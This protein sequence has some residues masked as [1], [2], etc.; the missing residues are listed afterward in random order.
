MKSVNRTILKRIIIYGFLILFF[1]AN[2]MAY[3]HAY[4]FTHFEDTT[5]VKT[6]KPEELSFGQKIQ[7]IILGI[8]NPKPLNT[9][10]PKVDYKTVTLSS[11]TE[12]A[13]WEIKADSSRGTVVL[14]HGYRGEKS[15]MLDKADVFLEMDFNVLLVDFMGCGSSEGYQTTIGFKEAQDVK[16][17]VD[18]L[19]GNKEEN[20]VLFGTSMGSVAILKAVHD[21]DLPISRV[22]I[23]CPFGTMLQTVKNRFSNMGLPGF[24]MA[25]LLT[26]WGGVQNGFNAFKHNPKDYAMTMD[27]PTL[28]LYGGNDI[29]VSRQE[30]NQIYSN[31]RGDK[32]L[33]IYPKAGHENYLINYSDEWRKDVAD[34]L[35]VIQ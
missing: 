32:R 8:N 30:I 14:F 9:S 34:F 26:F 31:L 13:C 6:T 29:K 3:F 22:I 1:F 10:T 18:Y 21:Y 15:S 27:C 28:L 17:C 23:E 16:A 19:A 24:P 5:N 20:I 2:L 12:I 35:E 4:R 25:H 7:T 33:R 11:N